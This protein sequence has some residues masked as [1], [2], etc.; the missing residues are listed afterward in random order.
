[1]RRRRWGLSVPALLAGVTVVGLAGA[2]LV[3]PHTHL[4]D[5]A[6]KEMSVGDRGRHL[7]ASPN[8]TAA[9]LA[10][11]APAYRGEPGYWAS[12]D[13]DRDG[14]ARAPMPKGR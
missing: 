1:M 6:L 14:I 7:L 11:L 3:L 8:C 10:R 12:H 2:L 5:P 13:A 9:R 4:A